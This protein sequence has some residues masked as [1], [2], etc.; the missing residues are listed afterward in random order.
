M[1]AGFIV[2]S[3]LFAL[4]AVPAYS[5]A[6]GLD[7]TALTFFL[8]S[9]FFTAAAF[10]QYRAAA[11]AVAVR[12]G[13]G[14]KIWVWAWRDMDWLTCVVQLAGTLWFNW[15]TGNAL[16]HNITAVAAD[17]RVWRP[18]LLGSIAF[19]VASGI[20]W[21]EAHHDAIRDRHRTRLWWIATLNVLGSVAFGVSAVTAYVVP[22][23]GNV[24][25]AELS[26]LGTFAGALCFLAGAVLLLPRSTTRTPTRS[27]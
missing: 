7:A 13:G 25:D 15:S 2:G 18:D 27:E 6:A 23:S 24:W 10:L 17:E 20:S 3:A 19:L 11:D 16:Q 1:A 26:N 9:L 22:A 4:G 12:R 21:A 8:G 14:R 5:A